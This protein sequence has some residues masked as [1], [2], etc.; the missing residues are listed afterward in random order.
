MLAKGAAPAKGRTRLV[1][2]HH[3]GPLI[4]QRPFEEWL[5]ALDAAG[6]PAC[7]AIN[8]V[9]LDDP[10][11]VAAHYS[12][13]VETAQVGRLEVLG[14]YADWD[15]VDR[16]APLPVDQLTAD[17]DAVIARWTTRDG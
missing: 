16:R 8:R 14:G 2:R 10:E 6:V 9:E 17:R 1:E 3:K 7:S 15:H 5:A 11:L 13:I 12:H 4:V